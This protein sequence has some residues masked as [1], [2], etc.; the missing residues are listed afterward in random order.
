M[1]KVLPIAPIQ[2]GMIPAYR[3][4]PEV[5]RPVRLCDQ[6]AAIAT[7]RVRNIS[8]FSDAA[9]RR[10][11]CDDFSKLTIAFESGAFDIAI[12]LV[13]DRETQSAAIAVR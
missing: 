13:L 1:R 7:T 5:T 9:P 11:P 2:H 8:G 12:S 10:W 3:R 6:L 4:Y